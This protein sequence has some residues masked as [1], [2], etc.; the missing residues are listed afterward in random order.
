LVLLFDA[1]GSH[2][3]VGDDWVGCGELGGYG[4]QGYVVAA[5]YI[6]DRPYLG[7]DVS[8]GGSVVEAG[9]WLG[10]C[11]EDARSEDPAVDDCDASFPA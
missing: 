11:G 1:A 8:A 6:F 10:S 2:A 7:D 5:A 9:V 3:D 4:S